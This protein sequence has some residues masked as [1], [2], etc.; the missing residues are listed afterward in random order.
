MFRLKITWLTHLLDVIYLFYHCK[1]SQNSIMVS[2]IE[3]VTKLFNGLFIFIRYMLVLDTSFIQQ[4]EQPPTLDLNFIRQYPLHTT[5]R[6][7][8][9]FTKPIFFMN[10]Q[11]IHICANVYNIVQITL[12]A[13]QI[14]P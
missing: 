5:N 14:K 13:I 1:E 6:N 9:I 3:M 12:F 8:Y 11:I 4:K 7:R 10:M 2:N